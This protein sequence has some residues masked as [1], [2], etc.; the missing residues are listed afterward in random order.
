V[1]G[2]LYPV[3]TILLARVVLHERVQAMQRV[4]VVAALVGVAFIAAG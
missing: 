1:L 3:V 4:G 2:S